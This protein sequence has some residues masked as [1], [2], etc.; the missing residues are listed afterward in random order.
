MQ[1]IDADDAPTS[2]GPFSQGIVDGNRVFVSGQGPV[3]PD[4]GDVVGADVRERTDRTLRNVEAVLSAA[5]CSLDDVVKT[6]VFLTDMSDYDAVNE[7]YQ[8]RFTDP[9][10]ARSAV[11]V[12]ELPIDIDV[13]IEVVAT[14]QDGD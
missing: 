8:E 5:G 3:D 10:P 11:Q 2:I 14:L 13:E 1:E 6:T 9:Y 12:S 7:A 4:T